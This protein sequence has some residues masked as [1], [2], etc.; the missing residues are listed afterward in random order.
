MEIELLGKKAIDI[1]K[2][3]WGLP[4]RGFV[5]GGSLANIIWEL[6]SG[7]KAV[8]NDI[9]IFVFD[10]L[11]DEVSDE[12]NLFDY[13]ERELNYYED[14]TGMCFTTVTK[15]FYSISESIRD[16]I[17]NT[18]SYESNTT[19]PSLVLKSFDL[20]CTRVGYSIEED[21]VYFTKDFEDFIRSGEMKICNIMTPSHTAIRM[22]K[23]SKELNIKLSDFEFDLIRH[24]LS[25]RFMD[26]LKT[27][28]KERYFEMYNLYEDILKHF[29]EVKRD[30][31][32]E[33]YVKT[34]FGNDDALYYLNPI[35][36]IESS[37]DDFFDIGVS[38]IKKVFDDDN[39]TWIF[40]SS[41]FLFYMRN[42]YGNSELSSI[43]KDIYY[44]WRDEQYLDIEVTKEDID[45][46]SRF[47]RYAPESINNLRGMKFS[48]QIGIIKMFLE[49]F[50]DDPIIAISILESVKLDK[51]IELDDQ[52][53]LILEL[54]VRKKIIN[55]T[56]GKVRNILGIN[57]DSHTIDEFTL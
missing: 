20:N 37:S 36:L 41:D 13:K 52:T 51:D 43:W 7:N 30:S 28:F 26:T 46:L 18:I 12:E 56:R 6:K 48:E 8:V 4:R 3:Q 42:V 24:S 34:T 38:H 40:R 47:A 32:L 29:F 15:E 11:V 21:R 39:L 53:A 31:D 22:A 49:K 55:D 25:T 1:I 10:K 16:G 5:A 54:S 44:F 23:K 33:L 2:S 14:Y 27:R 45:L 17:F 50:K 19:D 57:D 9:D 35:G